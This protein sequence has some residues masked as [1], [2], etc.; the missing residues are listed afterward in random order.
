MRSR[1]VMLALAAT[2]GAGLSAPQALAPQA[3]GVGQRAGRQGSADGL[4]R[5]GFLQR[6]PT[7]AKFKAQVDAL[8]STGLKGVGLHLRQHGRLLV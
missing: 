8:V 1:W 5:M 6:D 3:A 4:E 2:A 7:A